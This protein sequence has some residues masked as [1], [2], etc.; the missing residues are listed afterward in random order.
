MNEERVDM[1]RG[2]YVVYHV[3]DNFKME[4]I[5]LYGCKEKGLSS[6]EQ[7]LIWD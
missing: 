6:L 2:R 5:Y 7:D 1:G 4:K 3:N